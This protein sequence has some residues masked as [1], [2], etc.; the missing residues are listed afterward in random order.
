MGGGKSSTDE[1]VSTS[2][3]SINRIVLIYRAIKSGEYDQ[4][5]CEYSNVYVATLCPTNLIFGIDFQVSVSPVR[6]LIFR[7]RH[8]RNNNRASSK[9][10]IYNRYIT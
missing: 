4:Y 6:Y 5:C 10:K 8:S 7:E 3:W 9:L 2:L 1:E